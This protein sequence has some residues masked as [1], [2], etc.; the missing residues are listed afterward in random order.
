V[1]TAKELKAVIFV[2]G[3]TVYCGTAVSGKLSY[4]VGGRRGNECI[5]Y[6][7]L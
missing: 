4:T 2:R 5:G 7:G 6:R 1:S 3:F